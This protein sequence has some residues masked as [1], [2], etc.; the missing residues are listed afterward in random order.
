MQK[1]TTGRDDLN[2]HF[3]INIFVKL[4]HTRLMI[5]PMTCISIYTTTAC[6]FRVDFVVH[7]KFHLHIG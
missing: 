3:A 2:Q 6:K 5:F 4:Q 7:V 1:S